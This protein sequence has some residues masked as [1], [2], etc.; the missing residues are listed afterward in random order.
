MSGLGFE[1]LPQMYKNVLQWVRC[2]LSLF[3]E[4]ARALLWLSG[5]YK[6]RSPLKNQLSRL[7]WL[8]LLHVSKHTYNM[9]NEWT[10]I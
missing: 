10:W 5:L 3:L 7:T 2:L 1:S 6:M 4:I 8:V 9:L